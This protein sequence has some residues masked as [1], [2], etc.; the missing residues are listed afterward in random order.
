MFRIAYSSADMLSTYIDQFH[1]PILH[2]WLVFVASNRAIIEQQLVSGF[3]VGEARPLL[4][5]VLL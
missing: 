3:A 2:A 1:G 4:R 5:D